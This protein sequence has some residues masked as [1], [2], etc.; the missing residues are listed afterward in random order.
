MVASSKAL[1]LMVSK[2]VCQQRVLSEPCQLMCQKLVSE[3]VGVEIRS[4]NVF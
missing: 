4:R 2:S 3:S 1:E